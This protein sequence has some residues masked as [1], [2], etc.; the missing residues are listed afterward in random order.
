MNPLRSITVVALALSLT[1]AAF[2][3]E[4]G[5]R[6]GDR[7]SRGGFSGLGRSIDK[8]TLL[9]STQV[10]KELK[11]SGDQAKKIDK[12]LAAHRAKARELSRASRSRDL[13][14]EE[15]RER[16]EE[17]AKSR[18]ELAKR[19]AELRR[20]TEAELDAALKKGQRKR[21][22]AIALQQRG[23][24]GLVSER[25]VAAL[26]LSEETVKK[27]RAALSNRD[28]GL[29]ELRGLRRRRGDRG[30][31]GGSAEVRRKS[32]ALE[33]KAKETAL[34]LL[35]QAQ[36]QG[37]EKLKGKPFALD[38]SSFRRR[39]DRRGG[40]AGEGSPGLS[41]GA[42][43]PAFQLKDQNGRDVAL[44]DLRKKKGKVALVF[45]RSA[46]W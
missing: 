1:A 11:I 15:R 32:R 44:G 12:V 13:S 3:Q 36:L 4:R 18:Q 10:R 22:D 17:L 37:F 25:V 21:L 39:G 19:S 7:R 33:K 40:G 41:V 16:F 30:D 28:E 8:P 45:Y 29:R 31:R 34:A 27:I 26:E 6:G 43:A 46:D 14:R 35:S 5:D 42:S 38:R 9:G 24:D 2:A 20:K 23:I